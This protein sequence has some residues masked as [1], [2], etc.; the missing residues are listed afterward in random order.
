[1]ASDKETPEPRYYGQ[2]N[3]VVT[4]NADP[5]MIGRVKARIPGLHDETEW[6]LPYGGGSKQR[7]KWQVPKVGA[8][9]AIWFHRGDPHGNGYYEPGNWGRIEAPTFISGDPTVTPATAPL[10]AGVEDDRYYVVIDNR[11]GVQR[12]A[13]VDKVSG[14]KVELDG[15]LRRLNLFCTGTLTI[16]GGQVLINGARVVI[17]GRPVAPFGGAIG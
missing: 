7:G 11:P 17:N 8:D 13:L 2:E 5:L 16:S 12:A 9:V 6:L 15:K 3:G 14:D 10:I 4:A 1:M